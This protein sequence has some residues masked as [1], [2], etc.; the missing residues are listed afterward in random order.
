MAA[1]ECRLT[2]VSE[3]PHVEVGWVV[4]DC[5]DPLG[6]AQWWQQLIGGEVREDEDGDVAL[7]GGPAELLFL[8]VPEAKS[9][10][11][12]VHLDLRTTDYEAAIARATDLGA[13]TADDVYVG[14]R[15][16]V[17]RDPEGN[18][19]CIIRPT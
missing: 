10:K 11:N 5:A 7:R 16:S 2:G 18:E 14:N 6:L 4:I 12:R 17:L 3:I 1:P 8:A 13:T 9:V 15:W 19:F